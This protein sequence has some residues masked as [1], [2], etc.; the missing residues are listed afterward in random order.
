LIH[1]RKFIDKE[2]P[3]IEFTIKSVMRKALDKIIITEDM[4][5]IQANKFLRSSRNK[6]KD[7]W[8]LV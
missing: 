5:E 1:A 7:Q 3:R 4:K 6:F 8:V 2:N